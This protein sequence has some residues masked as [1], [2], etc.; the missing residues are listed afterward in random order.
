MT[1]SQVIQRADLQDQVYEMVKRR[2]LAGDLGSDARLTVQGLSDELAVSRTPV[3]HALNR[4][5]EQQL[6]DNE[7]RGFRVRPV[8]VRRME[9]A[10][11]VRCVLELHAAEQTVGHLDSLQRERLGTL[12][13]RTVEC[14]ENFEFVDKHEYML[15]N[16]AFH[17]Y[18]VDLAGNETLS[19]TYRSLNLHELVERILFSGPTRAAG[20][21]SGEHK[22][23][24]T[25]Y[26]RGDLEEARTAIIANV[27]TGRRIA[28]A[29]IDSSGGQL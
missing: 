24:V 5:V 29:M 8:T 27:E 26:E 28:V 17:E 23:I 11:K 19:E 7:R 2:V 20:N 22:A 12:L 10:H 6:L 15:A 13:D 18:L 4:L 25:A 1:N 14:V 21:S 3:H 16:K 9:E